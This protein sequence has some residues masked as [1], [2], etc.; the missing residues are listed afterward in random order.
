MKRSFAV[1]VVLLIFLLAMIAPAAACKI[2]VK[3]TCKSEQCEE[4]T[5]EINVTYEGNEG[6]NVKVV[7]TLQPDGSA[8][9][10]GYSDSE[11]AT[12][13]G[14]T[15][16][17]EGRVDKT[18]TGWSPADPIAFAPIG[19][20]WFSHVFSITVSTKEG[21]AN[22]VEALWF[23]GSR[24]GSKTMSINYDPPETCP[25]AAPEFPMLAF[26]AMMLVGLIG[27]IW[28]LKKGEE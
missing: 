20:G 12:V 18:T 4:I 17:W 23:N 3:K 27:A 26:P 16:I 13:V 8:T 5:F 24:G 25:T 9:I 2:D 28:F 14:N 10:T 19:N 6:Y 15:V 22:D 21:G 11:R 7:D 1:S